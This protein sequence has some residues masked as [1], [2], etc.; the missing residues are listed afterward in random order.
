M[1]KMPAVLTLVAVLVFLLG[2]G[3][4]AAGAPAGPLSD[5]PASTQTTGAAA[6]GV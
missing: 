3:S 4:A 6:G 2:G 1:K 5:E